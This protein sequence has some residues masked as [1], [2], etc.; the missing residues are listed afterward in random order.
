M[1]VTELPAEALHYPAD[2]LAEPV[3]K[4][5]GSEEDE[6]PKAPRTGL[7]S[8]RIPLGQVRGLVHLPVLVMIRI[9]V[10]AKST[11]SRSRFSRKRR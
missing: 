9:G 10:P 7:G 4:I 1:S 5:N 2:A 11:S 3:E 8:L 6:D